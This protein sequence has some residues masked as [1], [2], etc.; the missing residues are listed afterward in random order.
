MAYLMD[1]LTLSFPTVQEKKALNSPEFKEWEQLRSKCRIMLERGYFT[2][3]RDRLSDPE[4]LVLKQEQRLLRAIWEKYQFV[5]SDMQWSALGTKKSNSQYVQGYMGSREVTNLVDFCKLPQTKLKELREVANKLSLMV[6][7]FCYLNKRKILDINGEI[8]QA[9]GLRYVRD[10]EDEISQIADYTEQDLYVLCSANMYDL[11]QA[12]NDMEQR[13]V[14]FGGELIQV[15][16]LLNTITQ[17]QRNLFAIL[18]GNE[19]DTGVWEIGEDGECSENELR[20]LK[21]LVETI[22]PIQRSLLEFVEDTN[23]VDSWRKKMHNNHCGEV[24]KV[25]QEISGQVSWVKEMEKAL[26]ESY[27]KEI[28]ASKKTSWVI[29][30]AAT[31]PFLVVFAV[32]HGTSLMYGNVSARV[33]KCFDVVAPES[34]YLNKGFV[35]KRSEDYDNDH[36]TKQLELAL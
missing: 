9:N 29:P 21:I 10:L 5:P 27:A 15:K 28:K 31:M 12:E 1:F 20:H 19:G 35:R 11:A 26:K 6:L 7:P 17:I 8:F 25:L 24:S 30:E 14:I 16:A 2:G 3:C 34:F 18:D 33:C 36:V 13:E 4:K 32:P 22:M 23:G